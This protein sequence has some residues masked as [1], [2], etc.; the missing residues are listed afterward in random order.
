MPGMFF[1]SSVD[2]GLVDGFPA[3]FGAGLPPGF[4]ADCARVLVLVFAAGFL[5]ADRDFILAAAAGAC[6]ILAPC[7]IP[8]IAW[9]GMPDDGAPPACSIRRRIAVSATTRAWITGSRIMRAC[10]AA[11]AES[12]PDI[13]MPPMS[14]VLRPEAP[15]G[16][17]A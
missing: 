5:T 6:S 11:I 12:L 15:I 1:M 8:G 16:P 4:F 10:S 3:G 17:R 9:P 14:C 2:F 13:D 7:D